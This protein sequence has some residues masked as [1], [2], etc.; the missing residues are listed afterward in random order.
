MVLMWRS[1]CTVHMYVK[2]AF[3]VCG[4]EANYTVLLNDWFNVRTFHIDKCPQIGLFMWPSIA[5][6]PTQS[7]TQYTV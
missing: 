5:S 6:G 2:A 1:S 3:R 4:L 7:C